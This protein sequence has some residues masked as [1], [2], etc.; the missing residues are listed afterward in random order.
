MNFL[1][2]Q[3]QESDITSFAKCPTCQQLIKLEVENDRIITTAR[4]CPFCKIKIDED[5]IISS[6]SHNLTITKAMQS[7]GNVL[8]F[9]SAVLISF[10]VVFFE[11]F[12]SYFFET[13]SVIQHF[14]FSLS[15]FYF[16]SGYYLSKEWLNE[17]G[18]LQIK[19]EE[20]LSVRKNILLSHR[21]WFVASIFNLILWFV[22]FFIFS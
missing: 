8:G 9:D 2:S 19:D 10:G 18:S 6:H 15:I 3:K 22:Y 5:E 4:R 16:L 1:N 11:I 12:L 20:F 13:F 14:A 17:F 7:A 21:V